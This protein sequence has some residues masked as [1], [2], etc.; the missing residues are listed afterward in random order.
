MASVSGGTQTDDRPR[1]AYRRAAIGDYAAVRRADGDWT[2][3]EVVSVTRDHARV[4]RI[5]H[6]RLGEIEVGPRD[7]IRVASSDELDK[8]RA[9]KLWVDA[10]DS[11]PTWEAARDYLEPVRREHPW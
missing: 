4:R 7:E 8:M 9:A 6:R 1:E 3:G 5:I 10:P 11:F 2:L